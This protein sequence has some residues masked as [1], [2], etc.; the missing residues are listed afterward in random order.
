MNS[1]WT[2]KVERLRIDLAVGTQPHELRPQPVWVSLEAEGLLPVLP[3]ADDPGLDPE[4]LMQWLTRHWPA[5]PH[6][7]RLEL[8]LHELLAAVY[9]LDGRIHRVRAGLSKQRSGRGAHAVGLERDTTRAE[10]EAQQR[11]LAARP[12][13]VPAA[14]HGAVAGLVAAPVTH[15]APRITRDVSPVY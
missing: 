6:V 15:P 1:L 14:G 9:A 7:P 3:Q 2:L 13:P 8:R 5:T 12:A 4:P 11:Q 10:F